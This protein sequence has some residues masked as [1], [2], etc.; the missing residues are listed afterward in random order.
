MPLHEDMLREILL[1]LPPQPSSLLRASVVCKHWRGLVTDPR[2]LRRFRTHQGKPPLIGVF[3][4]RSHVNGINFRS[5]LDPPDRIPPERF[6]VQRQIDGRTGIRLL[7]CRHGRVLLL[8]LKRH[9]LIVCD[10][11]TSEHQCFA[12]PPVFRGLS[13]YGAVLCAAADQGHVHGSCHSSSFKVVLMS[14][15]GD[16]DEDEYNNTTPIACVYS[17]ETGVWGNIIA[18]ADQCELA[19]SNPGIL[20]GNVLYWSSKS[21]SNTTIFI[22]DLTDDIVEF[23]LDRPSLAVIKGPPCLNFSLRHQIIRAEDDALGLAIFSHCRFE[24]W[25]RMVNCH[26][27][28]TWL[29][30][31]AFETHTLLGLP[32]RI[33]G[34]KILGYDE[35]KDAIFLF[36]DANVYMVQL[37]SMQF[38]RLYESCYPIN[39]HPFASFYAADIA[40]P[41][42]RNGVGILHGA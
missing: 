21:V 41:E 23:D 35:D 9:K 18:A 30:H 29:L 15:G 25:Q 11:I 39:C 7:G 19:D 1:R 10:P 26:G 4:A 2:F 36:V 40:I 27:G 17:S 38:R 14:L 20:V 31:N 37:L 42:G 3:E 32:P 28:T 13:I 34:M 8:D 22:D 33:R 5:I 16:G 6:D 12:A 24:V